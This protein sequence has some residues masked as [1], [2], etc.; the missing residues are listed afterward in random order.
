MEWEVTTTNSMQDEKL[1][2]SLPGMAFVVW[3]VIYKPLGL[4]GEVM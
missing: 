1:T 3:F 2:M 4:V